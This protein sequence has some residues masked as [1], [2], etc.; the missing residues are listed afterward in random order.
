VSSLL[1]HDVSAFSLITEEVIH[2][3]TMGHCEKV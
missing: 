1:E 2:N 3:R